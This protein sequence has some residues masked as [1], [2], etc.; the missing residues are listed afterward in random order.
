MTTKE[1]LGFTQCALLQNG[2]VPL[3]YQGLDVS[4]KG[5][6]RKQVSVQPDNYTGIGETVVG[7]A[8]NAERQV[9]VCT[10]SIRTCSI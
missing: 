2:F 5:F 3:F 9:S 4:Q 7:R 6:N 10:C 1:L 8:L